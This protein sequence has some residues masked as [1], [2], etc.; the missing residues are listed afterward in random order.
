M[1]F[2]DAR[3]RN[4]ILITAAIIVSV[5][6]WLAFEIPKGTLSSSGDGS[7]VAEANL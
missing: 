4:A 6:G 3:L 1:Q 2:P 5:F 7:K